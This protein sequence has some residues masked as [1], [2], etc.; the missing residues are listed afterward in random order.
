MNRSCPLSELSGKCLRTNEHHIVTS[1]SS[2]VHIQE[3]QHIQHCHSG[4]HVHTSSIPLM[5][6]IHDMY[7]IAMAN[8]ICGTCLLASKGLYH[9]W[10]LKWQALVVAPSVWFLW[11]GYSYYSKSH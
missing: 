2:A 1:D 10:M 3:E 5:A 11:L 9:W 6:P 8:S 4:D 7:D